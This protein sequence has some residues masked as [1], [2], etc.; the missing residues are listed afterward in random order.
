[1]ELEQEIIK[2]RTTQ[3]VLLILARLFSVILCQLA[4]CFFSPFQVISKIN[5]FPKSQRLEIFKM[6]N[7]RALHFVFKIAER[8]LTAKFYREIL[9]MKVKLFFLPT[10]A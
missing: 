1:M 7:G 8:G 6:I 2:I 4:I 5:S 9:G 10:R 3:Q